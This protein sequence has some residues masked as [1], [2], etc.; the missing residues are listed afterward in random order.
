MPG[1]TEAC[2]SGAANTNIVATGG[3]ST[4]GITGKYEEIFWAD[5]SFEFASVTAMKDRANWD[6]GVAAG[7]LIYLGKGR[8][9]DQSEEAQFFTDNSLDIREEQTP[10]TKV[11]RMTSAICACSHAE[12]KKMEG[13]SGRI[14]IRTSKGFALGR[15]QDDKKIKGR[16]LSSLI[17]GSRTVPTEDQ[18][19]EYTVIDF[20]FGDND[21]DELNPAEVKV[22]FLFSEVDQVYPADGVVSGVSSNG[23]TLSLTLAITEDCGETVLENVVVAD[24]KAV[25]EDGN[26][27]TIASATESP[28]GTYAVDITTALT[29]AYISFDGIRDVNSAGTLYY[30]DQVTASV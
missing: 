13:K 25:D 15:L 10:A 4:K 17:V 11:I 2:A 5:D 12:I 6:A 29:T 27:L 8:F 3:I 18:P 24:L 21:G 9:E 23:S 22:D 1:Y 16:T 19:V 28:A 26:T 7:T 30:L 14:F 20:S